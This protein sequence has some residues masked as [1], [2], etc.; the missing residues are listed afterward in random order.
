[1][2]VG[3]VNR[4]DFMFVFIIEKFYMRHFLY[5]DNK[6]S[7]SREHKKKKTNHQWLEINACVIDRSNRIQLN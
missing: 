3:Q 1:M 2:I 5:R 4:I 7:T 6:Y